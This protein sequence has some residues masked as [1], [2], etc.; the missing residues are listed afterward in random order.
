M[1]NTKELKAPAKAV[2][3]KKTKDRSLAKSKA[4]SGWVFIAPFLIGFFLIYLPMILESLQFSFNDIQFDRGGGYHLEYQGF[5]FYEYALLEDTSFVKTLGS[6]VSQLLFNVPAIVIF[7]LFVAVLLNQKMVGRAVFR[8]IFFIPVIVSTGIIESIDLQNSLAETMGQYTESAGSSIN[9]AGGGASNSNN[10]LSAMD[11]AS[12]FQNMA[13][14]TELVTY[15]VDI[16]NGVYDIVN[17]SGVQMLIFLAG[18]QSISPAIYESCQMDGATSWET[19]WKITFPMISPMILVNAVY[20]VID[21]FTSQSN[22]MMKFIN[23]LNSGSSIANA[24]E[25]T[26]AMAW[27]YFLVVILILAVV[28]AIMGGYVFYQRREN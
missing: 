22:V 25:K 24:Q 27:M 28:A 8:A 23:G 10:L 19:F 21:S 26:T 5:A 12:F 2:K 9:A 1:T 20:T 15:I 3:V 17:K 13:I 7:S 6:S 4:R 18:L 16:V 11:V 14:G